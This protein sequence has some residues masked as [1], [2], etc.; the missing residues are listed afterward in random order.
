MQ[1]DTTYPNI[2]SFRKIE[3]EY[4]AWQITKIQAGTREFIGQKHISALD[5]RMW[6]DGYQKVLYSVTN[7]QAKSNT[8]WKTCINA[9]WIHTI[10]K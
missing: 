4:L 3:L 10:T 7:G 8:G 9:L 6:N 2:P 1:T 5:G